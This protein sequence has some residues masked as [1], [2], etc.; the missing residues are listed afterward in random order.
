MS[1]KKT[2]PDLDAILAD[3][4]AFSS[5]LNS[6]AAKKPE[7]SAQ[8]GPETKSAEKNARPAAPPMEEPAPAEGE[9]TTIFRSPT[10]GAQRREEP[11]E[12][13]PT[14]PASAAAALQPKQ[15][16][17]RESAPKP[18]DKAKPKKQQPKREKGRAGA[19]LIVLIAFVCM[20]LCS[21]GYRVLDANKP[22]PPTPQMHL[23][24]SL[25]SYF[26]EGDVSAQP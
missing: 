1:E 6:G 9:K 7:A 2:T 25:D 10:P 12:T 26:P 20:A 18:Q 17:P 11:K 16:L 22:A 19:W 3:F 14:Q 23:M 13:L 5:S 24:D 4:S 15:P 21:L 8:S